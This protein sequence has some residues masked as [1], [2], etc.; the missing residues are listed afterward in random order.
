MLEEPVGDSR[1]VSAGAATQRFIPFRRSDLVGMLERDGRLDEIEQARF[2]GFVEL[3][4]AVFHHEFHTRLEAL[5]DAYAPF[6]PDPDTRAVRRYDAEDRESARRRLVDG[7]R[8]LLDAGNFEPISDEDLRTA[9]DE[10]SLLKVRLDVDHSDFEDVLFFRRGV[11]VR[12][13]ELTS[14]F[15]LR[16]RPV[17][18][19]NYEK[20]LVLVTFK[21]AE[22]FHEQDPE[23]LSFTPGSTIL[24]LFQDVP[25]AD[26]EML[27]PNAEPRMRPIDK[28]M[29]GVP[30][31]VSGAVVFAT[32]LLTTLGLLLLLLAFWLGFRDQPVQLDQA[33]LVTL[34]A[35][36][37]SLGGYMTRQF[38]KFKNRKMKFMKTLSDSLYFRNLDND[39]GVLHHLIDDAEEEEVKEALLGWYF[40]R[41]GEGLTAEELDDAIEAWFR[42]QWSL[43]MDF[44]VNDGI[45]KL[46]E[47]GLLGAIDD[48]RLQAV[49]IDEA[50]RRLN[51]RWDRY[52]Q[53]ERPALDQ[54]Q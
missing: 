29:I 52:F 47:F 32:K 34:G 21:D 14:W 12:E 8:E 49:P 54:G 13:E 17:L 9:F 37:G 5:K 50:V 40:L 42:E 33:T 23:D 35:G 4:N 25:R 30:A 44:E 10:E 16:R 43:E 18:F 27:F 6:N 24:K 20:V 11:T 15:G 1:T 38:T 22:H 39:T 2:P 31:V 41:I 46:R 48:G 28:L 45:A 53:Y 7:L 26:L 19:R 3:L 36:L 51:E